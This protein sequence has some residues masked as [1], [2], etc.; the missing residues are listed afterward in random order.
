MNQGKN[1]I[2][3]GEAKNLKKF[4]LLVAENDGEL[5]NIASVITKDNIL[6]DSTKYKGT[7]VITFANILKWFN[8]VAIAEEKKN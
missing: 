6:R 8:K 3:D 2:R 5:Q 7:R 4:D 1:P